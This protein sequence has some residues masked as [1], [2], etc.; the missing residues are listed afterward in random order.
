[1]QHQIFR[2]CSA[3]QQ[4]GCSVGSLTGYERNVRWKN[5]N[6]LVGIEGYDGVKTGTTGS[7]GSCLVA[8]GSRGDDELIVVVLGSSSSDA[9]YADI[10][11]LFRWAWLEL[12]H[13]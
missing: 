9:R 6:R 12:G 8:R 10:R 5:T 11:N 1:M 4:Y 7:A 3:A 13:E 2:E